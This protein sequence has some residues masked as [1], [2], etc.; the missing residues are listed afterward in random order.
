VIVRI[1]LC[2]C[3]CVLCPAYSHTHTIF[4]MHSHIHFHTHTHTHT[5]THTQELLEDWGRST[6]E[7]L[8][9]VEDTMQLINKDLIV[10]GVDPTALD[11]LVASLA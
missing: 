9:I 10:H 4:N 8:S 11:A 1:C 5:Y 7:M 2:S 3:M 6:A